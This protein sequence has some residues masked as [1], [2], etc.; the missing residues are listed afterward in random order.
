MMG[1]AIDWSGLPVV[2]EMLGITDIE[3]MIKLMRIIL[4]NEQT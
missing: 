4:N 2:S 3:R 1:G